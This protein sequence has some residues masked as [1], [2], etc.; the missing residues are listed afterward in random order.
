MSENDF[1]EPDIEMLLRNAYIRY[2]KKAFKLAQKHC[3]DS[4]EIVEMIVNQHMQELFNKAMSNIEEQGS[5]KIDLQTKLDIKKE[6]FTF[7][8]GVENEL[9]KNSPFN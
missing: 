2:R 4:K 5:E 7:L 9:Q 6:I 3:V 8:I 1:L